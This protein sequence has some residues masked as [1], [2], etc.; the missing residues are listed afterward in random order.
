MNGEVGSDSLLGIASLTLSSLSLAAVIFFSLGYRKFR[1]ELEEMRDQA[2]KNL[3]RAEDLYE[4]ARRYGNLREKLERMARR[5]KVVH[6]R[7][8]T[9]GS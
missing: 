3:K 6:G 2:K 4:V 9:K 5:R 1:S 8:T 7:P